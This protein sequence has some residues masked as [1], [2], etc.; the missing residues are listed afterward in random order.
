MFLLI[1][2][3]WHIHDRHLCKNVQGCALVCVTNAYFDLI[4]DLHMNIAISLNLPLASYCVYKLASNNVQ[5]QTCYTCTCTCFSSVNALEVAGHVPEDQAVQVGV[6]IL[7]KPASTAM[8]TL[9]WDSGA[10]C[11]YMHC[12]TITVQGSPQSKQQFYEF[13]S[14]PN[15]SLELP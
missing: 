4:L 7:C 1:R 6:Q 2:I 13:H 3:T 9:W 8:E 12:Y 14:R 5:F 15:N 10:A 11:T